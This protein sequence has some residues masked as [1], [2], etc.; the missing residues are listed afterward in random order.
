MRPNGCGQ[1]RSRKKAGDKLFVQVKRGW[2][3]YTR[4]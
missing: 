4:Q 1:A 2:K 3:P